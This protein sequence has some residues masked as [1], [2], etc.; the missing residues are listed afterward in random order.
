MVPGRGDAAVDGCYAH[1][2][3]ST[4]PRTRF[5]YSR[6]FIKCCFYGGNVIDGI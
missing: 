6:D 1:P 5:F 3:D 2:W 4:F